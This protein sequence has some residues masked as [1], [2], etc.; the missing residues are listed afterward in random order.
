[1]GAEFILD[2]LFKGGK[3]SRWARHAGI[4]QSMASSMGTVAIP[5]LVEQGADN[6]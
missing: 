5:I 4:I 3:T 2:H 6:K 1:M